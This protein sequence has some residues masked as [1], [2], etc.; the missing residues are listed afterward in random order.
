VESLAGSGAITDCHYYVKYAE[1][2]LSGFNTVRYNSADV[3]VDYCKQKC[4]ERSTCQSFDYV[5]MGSGIND[6]CDISDS[7]CEP[8]QCSSDQSVNDHYHIFRYL[9]G[10]FVPAACTSSLPSGLNGTRTDGCY[11]VRAS[12][13]GG[14]PG[15]ITESTC[16]QDSNYFYIKQEC[17]LS[18]GYARINYEN[19][20]VDHYRGSTL[21]TFDV[22]GGTYVSGMKWWWRADETWSGAFSGN[23]DYLLQAQFKFTYSGSTH[24]SAEVQPNDFF[25]IPQCDPAVSTCQ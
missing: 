9:G 5:N 22:G 20:I 6:K 18:L 16:G 2:Y 15:S 13:A 17:I 19:V 12:T 7:K 23:T 10:A 25:V 24:E 4:S 1:K 11:V 3:S 14:A 8:A 21:Q